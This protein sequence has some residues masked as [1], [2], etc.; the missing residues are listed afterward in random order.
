MVDFKAGD[1]ARI[2]GNTRK[3]CGH[4]FRIG[5]EVEVLNKYSDSTY[6]VVGVFWHQLVYQGDM[7]L[8]KDT[9]KVGDKVEVISGPFAGLSGELLEHPSKFA[10][11]EGMFCIMHPDGERR[12]VKTEELKLETKETTMNLPFTATKTSISVCVNGKMFNITDTDAAFADL[13]AELQKPVHDIDAISDLLDKP[14]YLTKVSE[15]KV[16]VVDGNVMYEDHPVH[17][18]LTRKL[19]TMMSEG[20]DFKPWARFLDNLMDNPSYRSREALYDFLE[21]FST[22]ITEDGHFLAFKRVRENFYDIHSNT[23]DNSPGRVVEMDRKMV[24]DDN[25][26]TCSAGLHACASNYL[27]S[28]YA[29]LPGYKV[30]VV[31]INPADVVSVPKDYSFSKMRVCK[32]LVVAEAEEKDVEEL[33]SVEST[34]WDQDHQSVTWE[35][36]LEE[37]MLEED[38]EDAYSD[39]YDDSYSY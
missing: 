38:F 2:V 17:S 8:I 14:K 28:F 34:K 27:G 18:T 5:E 20:Y 37:I 11:E 23:M 19:L 36:V 26:R 25:D 24:D 33:S 30:V 13:K 22:P 3:V 4:Y 7:E 39:S 16:T 15:G 12:G 35:D 29:T 21:N 31:K 9:F 32:Y 1:K 6:E 10:R